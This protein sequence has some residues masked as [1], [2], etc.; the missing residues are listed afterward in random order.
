MAERKV[1]NRYYGKHFNHEKLVK[2]RK[3][4]NK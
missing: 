4:E 2:I 1:Q 3:A